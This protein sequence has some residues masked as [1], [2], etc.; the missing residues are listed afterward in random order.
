[1]I[2]TL[3][4][5]AMGEMFGYAFG[6][7]RAKEDLMEFEKSHH[8]YFTADDLKEVEALRGSNNL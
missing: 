5:G 4:A 1:M 3:F 6:P 7:G 8:S 2:V